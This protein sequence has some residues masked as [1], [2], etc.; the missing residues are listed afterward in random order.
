MA[1]ETVGDVFPEVVNTSDAPAKTVRVPEPGRRA[2][3]WLLLWMIPAVLVY[4][5]VANSVVDSKSASS[6]VSTCKSDWSKCANNLEM[7][8]NYEG[9]TEAEVKCKIAASKMAKYGTPEWPWLAFQHLTTA[10]DYKTTGVAVLL[11]MGAKFQNMYGAMVRMEAVSCDYDLRTK[12]VVD[13]FMEPYLNI[14]KGY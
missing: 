10:S 1:K 9:W 6:T 7:A 8:R 2:N 5:A 14:M 12:K 13:I 3:K 11:E 4:G